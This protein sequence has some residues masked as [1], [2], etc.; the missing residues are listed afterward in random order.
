M[1]GEVGTFLD[2]WDP[3]ELES[4]NEDALNHCEDVACPNCDGEGCDDCNY[5]G[6]VEL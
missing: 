1:Q 5:E 4:D 3:I 2:D 6:T